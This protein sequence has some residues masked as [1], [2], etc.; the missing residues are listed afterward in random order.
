M[1]ILGHLSRIRISIDFAR[2]D[3]NPDR[4]ENAM[5]IRI[6]VEKMSIK[7]KKGKKC[8]YVLKCSSSLSS[9]MCP[10]DFARLDSNPD[11]IGNAIRIR[12]QEEIMFI[13]KKL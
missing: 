7:K 2:L 5:K 6:Q 10:I 13:K 11:R 12:I 4:I 1:L 3:S 8:T 9:F